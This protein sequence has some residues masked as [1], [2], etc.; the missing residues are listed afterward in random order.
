MFVLKISCFFGFHRWNTIS[1]KRNQYIYRKTAICEHCAKFRTV[2][3]VLN[4]QQQQ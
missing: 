3:K 2:I 4:N 1:I